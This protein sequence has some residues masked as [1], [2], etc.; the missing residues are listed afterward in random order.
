MTNLKKITK[1]LRQEIVSYLLPFPSITSNL[2][3]RL[4][5]LIFAKTRFCSHIRF[6]GQCLKSNVIPKG[7]KINFTLR[8]TAPTRADLH[9][10]NRR[11]GVQGATYFVRDIILGPSLLAKT[12]GLKIMSHFF[13]FLTAVQYFFFYYI[14]APCNFFL[15]TSACRNFFFKITHPSPPSRVKWSAP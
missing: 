6:I 5:T 7:F 4:A 1:E 8:K 3:F 13:C 2:A 14:C 10:G 12:V 11:K 9:V 15:P